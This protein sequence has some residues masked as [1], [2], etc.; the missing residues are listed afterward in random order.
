MR[1]VMRDW[2]VDSRGV[3]YADSSAALAIANRKGAGKLCHINISSLW[4]QKKQDHH[5]V[6]M[7]KV[8]GTENPADLMTKYLARQLLDQHLD[9]LS[10]TRA[11]G[12]A[13]S[14]LDIQGKSQPTSTTPQVLGRLSAM[15]ASGPAPTAVRNKLAPE[16]KTSLLLGKPGGEDVRDPEKEPTRSAVDWPWQVASP[17]ATGG[18]VCVKRMRGGSPR[19]TKQPKTPLTAGMTHSEESY[20]LRAVSVP[21][22]GP[23]RQQPS[24]RCPPWR[25]TTTRKRRWAAGE[26]GGLTF[27]QAPGDGNSRGDWVSNTRSGPGRQQRIK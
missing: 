11:S 24:A 2:G 20:D 13:S 16:S 17:H 3:V 1:S 7:R 21:V 15:K 25:R 18:G 6:V 9:S 4:I 26:T 14:G 19:P 27:G 23:P 8:P 22:R 5:D 12:R 10:Q